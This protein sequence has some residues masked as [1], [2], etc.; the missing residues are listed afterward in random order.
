MTDQQPQ[1]EDA[2]RVG[3]GA[4]PARYRGLVALNLLAIA[5]LVVVSFAH[6]ASG[7]PA[8]NRVTGEYTM[9]AGEIQGRSEDAI[10]I[11][12]ARNREMLA[13]IWNRSQRRLEP[14]GA[15][16]RNLDIDAAGGGRRSR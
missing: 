10:Y 4:I 8:R 15:G 9:I 13:L 6:D 16:Y 7:Q 14:I 5:L 12:D 11:I 3:S 1:P 2:P